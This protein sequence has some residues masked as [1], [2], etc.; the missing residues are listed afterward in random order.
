[1][2]RGDDPVNALRPQRLLIASAASPS[3]HSVAVVPRGAHD[4]GWTLIWL[5]F[6]TF[7]WSLFWS[8]LWSFLRSFFWNFCWHFCWHWHFG[9][10]VCW[11]CY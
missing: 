11:T 10:H 6:W 7:F 4:P 2:R 5:L 9:W 1:M 3:A 8:F